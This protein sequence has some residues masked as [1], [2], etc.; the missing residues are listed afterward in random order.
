MKFNIFD[1]YLFIIH[2]ITFYCPPINRRRFRREFRERYKLDQERKW[3]ETG[4]LNR[5]CTCQSGQSDQSKNVEPFSTISHLKKI[6]KSILDYYSISNVYLIV[7]LLHTLSLFHLLIKS[8][9]HTLYAG[10]DREKI[11]YFES[12]YYPHIAGTAS[13]PYIFNHIIIGYTL[14][15]IIIKLF[16]FRT[17]IEVALNNRDKYTDLRVCQ[18]NSLYLATFYLSLKDWLA[19]FK[20]INKHENCT[21]LDEK[22]RLKHLEFNKSIQQVVSKMNDNDAMF[23]VNAIDFEKCYENSVLP[24]CIEKRKLY[25]DWHFPYPTPRLSLHGVRDVMLVAVL[26]TLNMI[27]GVT[28]TG[29]LFAYMELKTEFPADYSPSFIELIYV[30]P[31]HSLKLITWIRVTELSIVFSSQILAVYDLTCVFLDIH[32]IRSRAHKMVKVFENHIDFFQNQASNWKA[33]LEVPRQKQPIYLYIEKNSNS[34]LSSCSSKKALSNHYAEFNKQIR[35]DIVLVRLLHHELLNARKH[36][37][38]FF[39]MFI[40][41]GSISIAFLTPIILSTHLSIEKVLQSTI[42]MTFLIPI[43]AILFFCTKT[44]RMVSFLF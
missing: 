30:V 41:G 16:R 44:E 36:H 37:E 26:G 1:P 9:I 38:E 40:I 7:L 19:F 11:K 32:T 29:V 10:S 24:K 3:A 18:L 13:R 8:T 17:I 33:Q 39:N 31:N 42:L 27:V 28:I 21:H 4:F 5:T 35:H 2:K 15:L 20:Y 34:N 14:Y 23:F 22:I 12:I 6:H 43:M 25:E